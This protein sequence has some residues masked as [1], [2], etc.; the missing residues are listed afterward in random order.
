M[1]ELTTRKIGNSVG[2]IFPKEFAEKEHIKPNQK[3]NVQ[4]IKKADL[5]DL[6]GSLKTKQTGQEFKNMVRKGWD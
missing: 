5:T 6:F 3:I 1:V 2:V 4:L